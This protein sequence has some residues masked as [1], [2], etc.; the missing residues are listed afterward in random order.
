MRK[1]IMNSHSG[2][3][4]IEVLVSTVIGVIALYVLSNVVL[5]GARHDTILTVRQEN[6]DATEELKQVVK[7][8]ACG[9]VK[10][11]DSSK[12]GV[13]ASITLSGSNFFDKSSSSISGSVSGTYNE[14]PLNGASS[15]GLTSSQISFVNGMTYG[16]LKITDIRIMPLL[17]PT[18]AAKDYSYNFIS[19]NSVRAQI[20]V[21]FEPNVGVQ[22]IKPSVARYPVVLTL[23]ST[24]TS[25]VNCTNIEALANAQQMCE[26]SGGNWSQ[27]TLTCD[28]DLASKGRGT[29]NSCAVD[30]SCNVQS[31]YKL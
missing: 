9:I 5:Q 6:R 23:D 4:L 1:T 17:M 12:S 3:T 20:Q 26:I 19:T 11:V 21:A 2:F 14:I 31:Q 18:S 27:D 25:I 10:L 22:D 16:K 15:D 7:S 24:N 29:P 30:D 13:P 8:P 28:L